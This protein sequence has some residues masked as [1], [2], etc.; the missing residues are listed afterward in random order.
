[1]EV[2][3]EQRFLKKAEFKYGVYYLG[4]ARELIKTIPSE[5]VDL[6][7]TDPPFGLN[8]DKFDD[9]NVF[10]EI[11]DEMWR[12]LKKDAW[13]VFFYSIQKLPNVFK[14]KKFEYVWQIICHF[15]TTY[16]KSILGYRNYLP[17][18]V[19][20][21]GEPKIAYSRYDV[22]P[23][24]ELPFVVEK[25]NNPQFKP[26]FTIAVLLQMFSKENDL[27]LDPFARFGS[28]PIVAEYFKRRWIA[29]EVD[30]KKYNIAVKFLREGKV[31]RIGKLG[32]EEFSLEHFFET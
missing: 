24:E 9:P 32:K 8:T 2:I 23:A 25:V 29:F 26:T 18:L 21:K 17:I 14:L 1:M 5:S 19:F 16:S 12:V 22:I 28:I 20:K 6:I 30:E 27:V 7:L 10:F 15:P 31:G 11:E 3:A 4:D 13:L